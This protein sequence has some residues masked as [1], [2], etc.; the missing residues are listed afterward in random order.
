MTVFNGFFITI[1]FPHI[2]LFTFYSIINA[3]QAKF[4]SLVHHT[5]EMMKACIPMPS[6][7]LVLIVRS[8]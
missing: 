7:F 1:I 3:M 5:I 4:H 2:L 8:N 6:Y